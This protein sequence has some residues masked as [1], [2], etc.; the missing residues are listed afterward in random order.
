[1][2]TL[3]VLENVLLV[4]NSPTP[5]IREVAQALKDGKRLL[6]VN[7]DYLVELLD[8]FEYKTNYTIQTLWNCKERLGRAEQREAELLL[9]IKKLTNK[10]NELISNEPDPSVEPIG[11]PK[12]LHGGFSIHIIPLSKV[13]AFLN[14][15]V[16]RFADVYIKLDSKGNFMK[17]GT[18]EKELE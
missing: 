2:E 15:G 8:F 3:L 5:D 7:A 10:I 1:V 14:R 11:E 16:N 4:M 12:Y 6:E 18:S 9:E 17:F 13:A